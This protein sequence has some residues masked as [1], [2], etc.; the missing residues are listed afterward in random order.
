MFIG[1]LGLGLL[2]S[3]LWPAAPAWGLALSSQALDVLWGVLVLAGVETGHMVA[4][5]YPPLVSDNISLS[6]SLASA[7]ALGALALCLPALAPGLP[8][9]A[10]AFNIVGHWVLDLLVHDPDLTLFPWPGRK[11]GLCGWANWK[12][13]EWAAEVGLLAAGTALALPSAG[14]ALLCA[15]FCVVQT[16]D[17]FAAPAKQPTVKEVA[18]TAMLLNAVFSVAA[19]YLA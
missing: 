3:A 11:Y 18:C 16:L 17:T 10:V 4:G 6:H 8:G 19:W 13:A 7:L 12:I 1:H 15:L 14:G 9:T 5:K 2:S